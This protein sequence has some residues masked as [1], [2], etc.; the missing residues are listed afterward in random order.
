MPDV[1][2]LDIPDK[3]IDAADTVYGGQLPRDGLRQLLLRAAPF[4]VAA[5]LRRLADE[6]DPQAG[7]A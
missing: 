6:L 7:A 1:P 2:E 3:A 5:A 4:V